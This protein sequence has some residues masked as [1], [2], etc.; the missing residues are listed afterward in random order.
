M[1]NI[2]IEKSYT[3]YCRETSSKLFSRKSILSMP[4]PSETLYSSLLL[5]VQVMDYKNILKPRCWPI[6]FTSYKAFSKNKNKSV[7]GL[8]VLFSPVFFK[9]NVYLSCY[10][11]FT[12]KI[13]LSDYLYF[14]RYCVTGVFIV[15][16]CLTVDDVKILKL[17][18]AFLSSS[19]PTG[20]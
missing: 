12:D 8:L 7:T 15:I 17:S 1:R 19:S 6:I 14:L 13:S 3:K 11:L 4:Q 5:Y 2:F 10:I 9:K 20:P 16:I 18:W